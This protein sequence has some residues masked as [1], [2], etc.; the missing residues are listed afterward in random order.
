ML[1]YFIQAVALAI[2]SGRLPGLNLHDLDH[3][4]PSRPASKIDAGGDEN[5]AVKFTWPISAHCMYKLRNNVTWFSITM[6]LVIVVVVS[7]IHSMQGVCLCTLAFVIASFPGPAQ[8]SVACSTRGE[9]LG[10]RLHFN[11]PTGLQL[12]S[13]LR[14]P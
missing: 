2:C 8:L 12:N 14:K 13:Y 5:Q 7:Y 10:T 6:T 4:K 11:L 1:R 9:S 3:I